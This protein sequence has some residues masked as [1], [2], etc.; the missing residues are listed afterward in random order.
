MLDLENLKETR[1]KKG[2]TQMKVAKEVG[3]S[4][5]SYIR[6]ENGVANPTEEN[7]EKLE[8]IFN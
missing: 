8:K 1:I 7:L 4:L 5:N 2:L 3:V 6:W